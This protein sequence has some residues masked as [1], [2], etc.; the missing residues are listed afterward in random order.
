MW[1]IPT[2]KELDAIPD[3]Y[4]TEKIS[5]KDKLIYL[6]FFYGGCDWYIAE[7]SKE[8]DLF[9]GFAI[10][11]EDYVCAEWGYISFDELKEI[12]IKPFGFEIDCESDWTPRKACAIEKIK[13]AQGW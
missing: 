5:L 6:H 7:Y 10:L 9:W 1:N 12:K 2:K 4:Q 13:R 8:D 11:N 3:L